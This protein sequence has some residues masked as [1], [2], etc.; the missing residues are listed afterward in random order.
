MLFL[1]HIAEQRIAEAIERGEFSNLPG[2]GRPLDLEDDALV[3]QDLRMA[4]RI[5]KN[6]GL[7]PPEV[8]LLKELRN[9]EALLDSATDSSDRQHIFRKLEFLRLKLEEAGAS[10]TALR[11]GGVYLGALIARFGRSV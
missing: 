2:E 7:V 5:L 4:Y 10:A 8:G 6:S 1:D 9:L 11:T 3:P